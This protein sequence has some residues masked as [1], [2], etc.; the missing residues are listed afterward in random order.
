MKKTFCKTVVVF[1]VIAT[2][3]TGCRSTDEYKKFAKAGNEY[4][5]AVDKL[6]DAAS[7]RYRVE[8]KISNAIAKF[9]N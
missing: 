1:T 4:A 2:L 9:Q 6:L 3:T 8:K 7:E 5:N